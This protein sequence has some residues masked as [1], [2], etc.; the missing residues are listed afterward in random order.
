MK[1]SYIQPAIVIVAIQQE[2]CIASSIRETSG[3]EGLGVS[4]SGTNEGSVTEGN[5][6]SNNSGWGLEWDD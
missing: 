1:K 4:G 2:Q 6:K 3:A 5:T